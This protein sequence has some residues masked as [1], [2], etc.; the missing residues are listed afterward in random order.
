MEPDHEQNHLFTD[1]NLPPVQSSEVPATAETPADVWERDATRRVLDE[2]FSLTNQYRSSVAFHDLT[3]FVTRFRSYAP[4]NA[5]LIHV[6]MPGATFVA[7]P[8]RWFQCYRRRIQPGASPI[9]IL[10]P[11]GPVM[12]VFDVSETE[13]LQDAPSLPPEVENPFYAT[14]TKIGSGLCRLIDN[15]KRDGVRVTWSKQGSQ[16]AGSI[17]IRIAGKGV[18]GSQPAL[19]GFDS[20][21]NPI[22]VNIPVGFDL[23]VNSMLNRESQYATIVHELAHLY[24]GHL[25]SPNPKWWPDR[26]GMDSTSEEFEAESVAYLV[27]RRC[28][29]D[30]R[31]GQYLANFVSKHAQVPRISLELVMTSARLIETMTRKRLKIRT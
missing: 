14:G 28:Q 16:S 26:R 4:F 27:C 25:G 13:P 24:C 9:V 29:I 23:V 6:Q 17:A 2:L 22:M 31:S 5:M 3:E 7:S 10:R 21:R 1:V 12:F 19:S 15:G 30:S 11:M 18:S 8:S 20:H